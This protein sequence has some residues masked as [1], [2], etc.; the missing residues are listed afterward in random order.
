[1]HRQLGCP[2]TR[3]VQLRRGPSG[4]T[5]RSAGPRACSSRPPGRRTARVRPSAHHG[6]DRTPSATAGP[7]TS[8]RSR[9]A[10]PGPA[11]CPTAIRSSTTATVARALGRQPEQPSGGVGR[12]DDRVGPALGQQVG[13]LLPRGPRR[14]RSPCGASC[15]TV[16]VVSTAVS[17]RLT[18]TMTARGLSTSASRSTSSLVEEPCT[19]TSPAA[20]ACD[21]LGVALDDDDLLGRHAAAAAAPGPRCGPSCRIRRRRRGPSRVTSSGRP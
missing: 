12:R 10:P 17:S 8:S 11:R 18:A 9:R 2:P 1:M 14:R 4:W 7:P 21:R 20:A 3:C 6:E 19:V 13:V 16:S 5:R 15:R